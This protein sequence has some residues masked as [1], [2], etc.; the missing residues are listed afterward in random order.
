M[1]SAPPQDV[2]AQLRSDVEGVVWPP[3]ASGMPA[4]VLALLHQLEHTQWLSRAQLEAG[5]RSQLRALLAHAAL[6]SEHFK[7][8]LAGAGLTP[9]ALA[10]PGGLAELPPLTRRDLQ[11]HGAR[12]RARQIPAAH[13]PTGEVSTSGSSGTPVVATRSAINQ[14]FWLA[15]TLREHVWQRRDF[16]ATLAVTRA[17]LG[18]EQPLVFADWGAP[19]ASF[20]HT[21]RAYAMPI[22]RPLEQQL[23]WLREID[24]AYLLTYPTNLAALLDEVERGALRLPGLRQLRTIGETVPARLRG[25]ARALL[26]VGIADTYSSQELGTVAIQC[27][28]SD[29]Y[30]LMAEGYLVEVLNDAGAPCGD[31]ETGRLV[32]TDL[33]NF[34]MPLIR[35]D[36][37][38]Y[39]EVGPACA[40]GRGL[41]TLR[42]IVGRE[43]NMVNIHGQRHWPLLGFYRFREVAEVV[44]YQLVQLNAEQIEFRL[45]CHAGL[46]EAQR[47]QLGDIV[48]QALGY[49][50][51]VSFELYPERIPLPPSGKFEEFVSLV[52]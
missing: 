33:H 45:V 49:P 41:P 47:R 20:F 46:S 8:R 43:R 4:A 11:A 3:L 18:S 14:R 51:S 34:A 6:H 31:G 28:D 50:F 24:P 17:N 39:A 21:G 15:F 32:I 16:S 44:Q 48:R 42:R 29:L 25:R 36:I 40:C 22:N 30:H 10:E 37:G 5:Q 13:Q 2:F 27:P 12:I 35:Y 9:E 38:D 23:A 19:T 7:E 1:T 52:V 26:D